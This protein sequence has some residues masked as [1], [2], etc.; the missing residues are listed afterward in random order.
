MKTL[1]K[2]LP[3]VLVIAMLLSTGLAFAAPSREKDNKRTVTNTSNPKEGRSE[4]ESST[5]EQEKQEDTKK[6]SQVDKAS[7][8]AFYQSI[9]EER[10][11]LSVKRKEIRDIQKANRSLVKQIRER[12]NQ[13]KEEGAENLSDEQIEAIIT[14]CN[15]LKEISGNTYTHVKDNRKLWENYR[16]SVKSGDFD[17]AKTSL[18]YMYGSYDEVLKQMKETGDMLAYLLSALF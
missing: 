7:R 11:N 1:A 16:Q 14:A 5:R 3:I 2:A 18:D 8:L 15:A 13:L 6:T 4:E 9:R 12:I 17:S 10:D